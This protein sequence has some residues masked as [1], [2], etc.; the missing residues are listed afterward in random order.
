MAELKISKSR[1]KIK[2]EKHRNKRKWTAIEIFCKISEDQL[3]LSQY[4]SK[5]VQNMKYSKD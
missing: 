2:V 4:K 5:Q 3:R 1:K